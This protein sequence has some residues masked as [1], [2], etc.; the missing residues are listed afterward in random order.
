MRFI[1]NIIWVVFGGLV[2]AIAWTAAGLLL[3]ITIIG[4]PFGA[5]CL[6]IAS[7]T[8]WPFG[9][10]IEAGEFGG[11]GLIANLIWLLLFGWELFIYHAVLGMLFALTVVGLPFGKQHFKLALLAFVPFGARIR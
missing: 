5:Q 8:L 3:M 10:E 1:G 7:L 4:I 2:G 6:K 9:H 11:L